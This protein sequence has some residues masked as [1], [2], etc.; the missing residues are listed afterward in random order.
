LGTG[1]DDGLSKLQ[2][3]GNITANAFTGNGANLIS[4]TAGNLLGTIP[5]A[6][7]GNSTHYVG[8]TAIALNRASASLAL[9]GITSIDG[10]A[11]SV[12][13]A[14]T[15]N[16]GGAGDASGTTFNGS[17]AKTISY[18]SI[19]ASPLAG[20]SS[21]TTTGTVTSGTW[22]GS[23]GAVS[24]ANLT[25]LTAGNLSGTI[26]SA[27][28]GNSTHY[29]GTTAVT[30]NRASASQ[31]LTGVNIDGNAATV[32]T[33]TFSGDSVDKD[34]ITTRTESGF[35]QTSTGTTA[36]GWPLNSTQWQHMIAC[37]HSN[38]ANYYSMQIGGSFFDNLF[39]GRKVNG[40]G[41]TAW[42]NFLTSGN[43]TT[44]P[45]VNI[46]GGVANQIHYQTAANTTNFIAAPTTA[47]T[48]LQWNGSA[49]TWASAEVTVATSAF[50]QANAAY[51]QANTGVTVAQAA[52]AK[53]NTGG[54]LPSS[55]TSGNIL[56]SNG[57]SW[58]SSSVISNP[59]ITNY[60]E[61]VVA[62]GTVSSASTIS[63]T[64]GTVQTATLTASTACTFTMPTAVAG[65]SFVLLLKQAATTGNGTATFTGVKWVTTPV[66][67]ATAGKMDIITFVSDGTNWYGS[68]AQGYTP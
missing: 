30:L 63:L 52:F 15:F 64:N 59:T 65:K 13:N 17:A 39:Y 45:A 27:V 33:P 37:T 56:T 3:S 4:V 67:T 50:G 49:F 47:S 6:V 16:N 40:S 2:V 14:V 48:F 68:I 20:S 35:Y 61:S 41:T 19:G 38:D 43:Y 29:I 28:L 31:T 18:N 58:I 8:T 12:T 53:A 60:V 57:I 5:S 11:A 25:G 22:S 51:T 66:I 44:Y 46:S 42:V 24:G 9:T 62:I 34:D 23:F 55:G 26:P 36:E 54:G 1:T 21:I 7:L 10:S 32:T